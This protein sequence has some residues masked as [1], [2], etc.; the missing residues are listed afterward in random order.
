MM[1]NPLSFPFWFGGLLFCCFSRDAK[2]YRLFGWGFVFTI[3]AFMITH[4]KDYYSAPAYVMLFPAGAVATE[5]LLGGLSK[6]P[7]VQA[8]LKPACFLWLLLAIVPLLP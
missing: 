6:R 4:G 7:L 3:A 5:K 2:N 1:M 8:V